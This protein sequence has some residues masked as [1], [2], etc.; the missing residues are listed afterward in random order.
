M[1]GYGMHSF[2]LL[3]CLP[4]VLYTTHG[5]L[6]ST[7]DSPS[8]SLDDYATA[9]GRTPIEP[10]LDASKQI[11]DARPYSWPWV[12]TLCG[13]CGHGIPAV[14]GNSLGTVIG[15]RWVLTSEFN[16]KLEPVG[17]LVTVDS[18][19]TGVYSFLSVSS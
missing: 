8:S 1:I 6:A 15:R 13:S 3:L 11:E 7:A 16:E 18:V 17:G 12:A 9:C 19:R 2:R 10:R 4:A 14:Y 5:L